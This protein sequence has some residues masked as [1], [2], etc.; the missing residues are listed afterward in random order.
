MNI[1]TA[2]N[3]QD[4][5]LID[6]GNGQRLERFGQYTLVRP[7][8]Q[9]I[10]KPSLPKSEWDKADAIFEKTSGD[11]GSWIKNKNMPDK[12]LCK[13]QNLSFWVK[14]SPFKHTG[15]FPEQSV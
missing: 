3:W 9:I 4:Y 1:L 6:T 12:W 13:Y 8:P 14:L 7:D 2:Q 15:V 11:K 10:W 5:E